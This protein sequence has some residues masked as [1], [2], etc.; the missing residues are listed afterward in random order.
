MSDYGIFESDEAAQDRPQAQARTAARHLDAAINEV[1]KGFGRFLLG[2]TGIDEFEDRW[3]LSKHDIRSSVEPYVFPNTG[4]MRRIQNAMKADWKLAHP[5]KLALED[6]ETPTGGSLEGP[7]DLGFGDLPEGVRPESEDDL[8]MPMVDKITQQYHDDPFRKQGPELDPAAGHA[9]FG[10]F[11]RFGPDSWDYDAINR[12]TDARQ[13]HERNRTSTRHYAEDRDAPFQDLD[14]TYH[15]SSGNLV[16]DGNFQAYED[17]VDQGGPE[18]VQN[19]FTPGGDSGS[20]RQA[21]VDVEA[22]RLVADIYT[23][24]A[25]SNGLRVASM[26]SLDAYASTGIA[27]ADYRI[28]ASLIRIAEEEAEEAEE[29]DEDEA[30]DFGGEEPDE[31]DEDEDDSDDDADGDEDYGF[32]DDEDEEGGEEGGQT[33]TV[34]EQAPELDPQLL[35]EIPHDDPQGSAPVP[36]EVIDSL[37]GLPEGTIE[38]LLLEEV[39]QGQGGGDGFGGPPQGGPPPGGPEQGGAP[40]GGGEDFFGG[41]G[42][43]TEQE[44]PRV[45]RRRRNARSFWAAE[46]DEQPAEG[47]DGAPAAPPAQDPAAAGGAPP[48]DPNAMGGMQ[49][50]MLPP[51]GSQAVQP[52]QPPMPLE[53]QPAEDALLDTANQAIM[54]MIDRETQEYQQIIDPLSQALQAVQF[55]QQVEQSEHPLDVTPPQGTVNVDP[56]AAPGGAQGMQQQSSRRRHAADPRDYFGNDGQEDKY[57]HR[58]KRWEEEN[59]HLDGTWDGSS[60]PKREDFSEKPRFNYDEDFYKGTGEG[61]DWK[62]SS[63]RRAKVEF[64]LRNA[65]RLIAHRYRLSSTGER[66][67]LEAMG[68]RNY[69]HVREALALV[70]PE[71]RKGAAIHMGEMFAADNPRFNKDAWMKTVMASNPRDRAGDA[72]RDGRDRGEREHGRHDMDEGYYRDEND[73]NSWEPHNDGYQ[74]GNITGSRGRLP[75]DRPRLAG[76]TWTNTPTKDAFE[77]PHQGEVPKVDDNNKTNDLPKMKGAS[78]SDAV[79]RFQRWQQRQQQNGLPTTEGEAAVHDFLQT[80]NPAK[81]QKVGPVA[82]G[83]IHKSLGLQPDAPAAPRVKVPR[84]V[85]PALSRPKAA[86]A[87]PKTA[88]WGE[89]EPAKEASFFTRKVPGWKWDDHLSG[90]LSKE[91]RAFACSCGEKIAVPSYTNCKCGS[92]WN[93]YAVGDTHHL[94]SDTADMYIV[95]SI[96][97]R[98]GVIMANKKMAGPAKKSQ[99]EL[100][101]EIERLADW[102]IYDGPDPSR[103]GG[104]KKPPS[105]T[106]PSQPRDWAKRDPNGTWQGPAIPH[107]KK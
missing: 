93:A 45:A 66:M 51:P 17:S 43:D 61:P 87:A 59:P 95:R 68:R 62:Q 98:P 92:V 89:W 91:A 79:S 100:L 4:T 55:A 37:L 44:P 73:P 3:H 26:R 22:A 78:A 14:E 77:F 102:T 38:Q 99:R 81:T 105:T 21:S 97:V 20:G 34:P 56:S 10:E 15:P 31:S 67:L 23:D 106:I 16:P 71:T 72:W 84:A 103:E 47:G 63:R 70:P 107:K 82:A 46:G 83:E 28:L 40:Q 49:Q 35:N 5:Y 52:P 85:N 29:S 7:M 41:G 42:D 90:Y 64:A 24:F 65:A 69:E 96:P 27:D 11:S 88:T 54:Q 76:E 2:A 75:F 18:K 39:E 60:Y 58:Q 13:E 36:P 57:N 86:P 19:A 33:Y 12:M 25:Q 101:A 74:P 1:R 8:D 53:N 48:M 80:S 104:P 94:A 9:G 30:P 6:G 32:G 50:P